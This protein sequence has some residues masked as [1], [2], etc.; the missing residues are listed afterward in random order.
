MGCNLYKTYCSLSV[1][2]HSLVGI[3]YS[4]MFASSFFL[5]DL[6]CHHKET[7][8][9]LLKGNLGGARVRGDMENTE[10][11]LNEMQVGWNLEHA[12]V[13]RSHHVELDTCL[14]ILPPLPCR[15]PTENLIITTLLHLCG[16]WPSHCLQSVRLFPCAALH[17]LLFYLTNTTT[18]S[19]CTTQLCT[20]NG[21]K[22]LSCISNSLNNTHYFLF[23]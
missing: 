10:M 13:S 1:F 20:T 7:N 19:Y 18:I 16:Y 11:R 9:I 4:K 2:N 6:L 21:T 8:G 17:I 12:E 23:V 15:R 14:S 3:H 5:M 22:C